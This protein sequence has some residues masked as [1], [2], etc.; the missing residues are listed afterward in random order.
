MINLKFKSTL[1]TSILPSPNNRFIQQLIN[2][3]NSDFLE[4][5][6]PVKLEKYATISN[7]FNNVE[8][9]VELDG[10]KIHYGWAI[11]Q[12]RFICEAERHAVWENNNKE[13]IDITPRP[14]KL[15]K[16]LFVS[17]N[18]FEYRGQVIDNYRL[19]MTK[20]KVVDH[21]ILICETLTKLYSNGIRN[22]ENKLEFD[23]HTHKLIQYYKLLK[24]TIKQ[25]LIKGGNLRTP[26]VCGSK[27][28]YKNCHQLIIPRQ[29][30]SLKRRKTVFI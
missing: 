18:N 19:N 24:L 30:K 3:I 15:E 2:K 8:K 10:G 6:I 26:C 23:T 9:K 11:F 12:S 21:F 4:E 17:D 14:I 25:Y 28:I 16:T 7:C 27:K 1:K 29:I 13:L 22:S 20:N 5:F